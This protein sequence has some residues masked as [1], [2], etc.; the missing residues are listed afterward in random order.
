MKNKFVPKRGFK[1]SS[2]KELESF[3]VPI[4]RGD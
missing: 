4:R 2:F 3:V 1:F